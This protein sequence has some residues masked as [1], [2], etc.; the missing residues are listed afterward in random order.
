MIGEYVL[1][2]GRA[3][4]L[5]GGFTGLFLASLATVLCYSTV[6]LSLAEM[7]SM[8]PTSSGM[9][10]WTSQYGPAKYRKLLSYT[11]GWMSTLGWVTSVSCSAYIVAEL[12]QAVQVIHRAKHVFGYYELT[13]AVLGSIIMCWLANI[14]V[15]KRLPTLQKFALWCHLPAAIVIMIAILLFRT[16]S[17][18]TSREVFQ[19]AATSSG[20]PVGIA[21][22]INQAG[23]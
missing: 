13:F 8:A 1:V 22:L 17:L 19:H 5:G 16:G 23:M 6:V 18:N 21:C 11:S 4:F 9:Y 20:W 7:S 12:A 3:G 14:W 2:S 15:F 10:Y